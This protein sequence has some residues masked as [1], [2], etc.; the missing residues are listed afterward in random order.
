MVYKR[1]MKAMWER[2]SGEDVE[3]EDSS[4][5]DSDEE[6]QTSQMEIVLELTKEIG[7]MKKMWCMAHGQIDAINK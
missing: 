7:R 1:R 2:R 5:G 3:E 4:D 6:S